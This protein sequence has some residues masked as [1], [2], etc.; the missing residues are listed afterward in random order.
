MGQ[1]PEV[2]ES[3]VKLH[4]KLKAEVDFQQRLYELVGS[5]DLLL[6]SGDKA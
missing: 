6:A 5:L 4:R 3:F 1:S 2:D